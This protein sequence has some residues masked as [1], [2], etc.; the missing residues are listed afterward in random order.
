MFALYFAFG[1]FAVA[2]GAVFREDFGARGGRVR[3][4]GKRIG[5]ATISRGNPMQ[6]FT[7]A[8]FGEEDADEGQNH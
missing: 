4:A 7:I 3:I 6:P 1:I 8:R 5:S 2:R